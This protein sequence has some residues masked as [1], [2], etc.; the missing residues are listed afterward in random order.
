MKFGMKIAQIC[1]A[2]KS[3]GSLD[4]AG[5]LYHGRVAA[6]AKAPARVG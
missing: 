3:T 6:L 4:R 2:K 1:K 5:Y